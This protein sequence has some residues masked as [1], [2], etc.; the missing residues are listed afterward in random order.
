MSNTVLMSSF[1]TPYLTRRLFDGHYSRAEVTSKLTKLYK[2]SLETDGQL[3]ID[4]VVDLAC[5]NYDNQRLTKKICTG[6]ELIFKNFRVFWEFF[7]IL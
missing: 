5:D 2:D 6:D 4:S 1:R 7:L 3:F